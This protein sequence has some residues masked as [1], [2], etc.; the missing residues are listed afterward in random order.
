MTEQYLNEAGEPVTAAEMVTEL[1]GLLQL[2]YDSSERALHLYLA[3]HP[4]SESFPDG[5]LAFVEMVT[6]YEKRIVELEARLGWLKRHCPMLIL[7]AYCD[8]LSR[9]SPNE[10]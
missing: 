7:L 2:H 9:E 8:W 3:R 1:R 6:G 4:D 10:L 5:P